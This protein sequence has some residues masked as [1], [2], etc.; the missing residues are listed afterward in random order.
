MLQ[1]VIILTHQSKQSRINSDQKRGGGAQQFFCV[2]FLWPK[3][4]GYSANMLPPTTAYP[5]NFGSLVILV[6]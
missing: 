2:H 1:E 6:I 3:I 4:L 5:L